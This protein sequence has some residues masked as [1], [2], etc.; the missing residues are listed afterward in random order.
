MEAGRKV[1]YKQK[2]YELYYL[3]NSGY[4]EIKRDLYTVELVHQSEIQFINEKGE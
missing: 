1:L 3:Y 4:C 2:I